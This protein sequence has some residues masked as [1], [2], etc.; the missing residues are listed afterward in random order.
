M[1]ALALRGRTRATFVD[2]DG[3]IAAGSPL[4]LA[5]GTDP[6]LDVPVQFASDHLLRR[7]AQTASE[8]DNAGVGWTPR[9]RPQGA[10]ESGDA[11][12]VLD[13]AATYFASTTPSSPARPRSAT[14]T[15]GTG[16]PV[17]ATAHRRQWRT[18]RVIP[19]R[20]NKEHENA[21]DS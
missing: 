18:F 12:V 5:S 10:K 1:D 14:C 15:R 9:S 21:R 4:R 19:I 16:A 20:T 6:S 13:A 2:E 17:S 8:L 11:A 3:T 7:A